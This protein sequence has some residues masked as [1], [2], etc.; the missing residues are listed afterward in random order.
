MLYIKDVFEQSIEI[1]KSKF[2]AI[3]YP[4][5]DFFSI[6]DAIADAIHRYP[7]ANHYCRA[8]IEGTHGEQHTMSDDG[9]PQRTAGLP[10]LEVLKHH[11]VTDVCCIVVRYFGGIKL[12]AGGLVRAYTKATTEVLLLTQFYEKKQASV[13]EITF[14]Y[15]LIDILEHQLKDVA[16]ILD[17]QF[18]EHVTFE[19][20]FDKGSIDILEHLKHQLITMQEKESKTL[21]IE[22]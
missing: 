14:G 9:E 21:Y 3:L 1:N 11:Q 13:Y 7:K 5:N 12:G 16:T 18:L 20:V 6:D 2:I 15:H 22:V 17:R 8:T 10:I 19:I 4:L